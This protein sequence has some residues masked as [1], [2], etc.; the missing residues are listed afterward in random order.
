M[1]LRLKEN[2][3]GKKSWV[4]FPP[5]AQ[6]STTCGIC[7]LCIF[8]ISVFSGYYFPCLSL[9]RR[10]QLSVIWLNMSRPPSNTPPTLHPCNV[11]KF[12]RYSTGL[13]PAAEEKLKSFTWIKILKPTVWKCSMTSWSPG[14]KTLTQKYEERILFWVL[15]HFHCWNIELQ[16]ILHSLFIGWLFNSYKSIVSC[17]L[18]KPLY[19]KS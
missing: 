12:M 9:P 16:L 4:C 18:S 17:K 8:A 13:L 6:S 14:F 5:F 10:T 3:S 15:Y 2:L 1:L 7:H 19:V 11:N